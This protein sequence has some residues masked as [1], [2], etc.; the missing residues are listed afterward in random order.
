MFFAIIKSIMMLGRAKRKAVNLLAVGIVMAMA[1]V[2]MI[3]TYFFYKTALDSIESNSLEAVSTIALTIDPEMIYALDEG[4]SEDNPT[5]IKE[6]ARFERI[7]S[8]NDEFVFLYLMGVQ[9]HGQSTFFYIDSDTADNAAAPGQIYEETTSK[10]WAAIDSGVAQFDSLNDGED[11]DEWGT[12]ISA[13][14]PIKDKDGQVIAMLGIDINQNEY[15]WTIV[16]QTSPP[17]LIFIFF[18]GILLLYRY[19]VKREHRRLEREK[20]LLS[21]ASHEVRSPMVS[22]KWILDDILSRDDGLSEYNR[23]LIM[24]VDDNT[25]KIIDSIN[26]ILSSTPNWGNGVRGTDIIKV[27]DLLTNIIDRLSLVAKEHDTVVRID[28]SLTPDVVVKSSDHGLNHAFY[29]IINNALK[30]N[31]PDTEVKIEY[32]HRNGIHY[33]RIGDHGVGVK[34]ED[35]EKIFEGHYRTE[36]A[37]KSGEPGTGLGLYFVRK[38][39]T[40]QKGKIYV[41]PTYE[42]GTAFVVELP[43]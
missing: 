15:L 43:E 41:D 16:V 21:V 7:V 30:Y 1:V 34:P 36:E 31:R 38:I 20:E 19:S 23:G 35:R 29:N 24:G 27:R 6:K 39:I 11:T 4:A 10:M 40:D 22:V 28:D 5:Y 17:V 25:G 26:A 3:T 2:T 13:Y 14:A 42:V 12:F 18:L 9:E 8:A 33:F 32:A 37:K